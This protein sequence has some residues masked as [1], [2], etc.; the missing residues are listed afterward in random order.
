[1]INGE[2]QKI[3]G[4]LRNWSEIKYEVRPTNLPNLTISTNRLMIVWRLSGIPTRNSDRS[5][6]GICRS[7]IGRFERSQ[8]AIVHGLCR[9]VD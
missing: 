4:D 5:I 2:H 1:M 7:I 6:T 9:F 3:I 8:G